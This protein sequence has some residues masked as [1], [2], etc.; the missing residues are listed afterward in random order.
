MSPFETAEHREGAADEQVR[1]RRYLRF[2]GCAEDLVDDLTQE[3]LLAGLRRPEPGPAPLPWLLAAARN[4]L[5]K[6]LRDRGRRKEILDVERLDELWSRHVVDNGDEMRDALRACLE[7]LP[8]RSREVLDLR[9]GEGLNRA[10][11][12]A[13]VDLQ[14]EG[15]KSLL[16]RLRA[17]LTEC[18]ER[19]IK[20][21]GQATT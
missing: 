9:Y 1:I 4:Q 18:I 17:A 5:R 12:S 7:T 16:A 14:P 15:V 13:R 6:A 21:D 20:N 8:A 3:A 2:L 11:I 10:A 19:R